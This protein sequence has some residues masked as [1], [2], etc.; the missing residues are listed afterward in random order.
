MV[1]TKRKKKESLRGDSFFLF[2]LFLQL[3]DEFWD[4]DGGAFLDV[5]DG[6]ADVGRFH[7]GRVGWVNDIDWDIRTDVC[8]KRCG[9]ID[10]QRCAYDDE[11]ISLLGYLDGFGEHRDRFAEEN[12]IRT[13]KRTIGMTG[14]EKLFPTVE[15]HC[16]QFVD[17]AAEFGDLAMQVS[18]VFGSGAFVEVINVLRD[19][20]DIVSLLQFRQSDMGSVRLAVEHLA[21]A[22]IIEVNDQFSVP[23][24]SLRGADILDAV[25][26]PE[27]IRVAE[28]GD[29][30]VF[31]DSC[32]CKNDNHSFIVFLVVDFCFCN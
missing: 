18:D 22:L 21:A 19:D 16:G 12:H 5:G 9:R 8:R 30:A 7:V 24:Q 15:R 14:I 4:S 20:M 23:G 1:I 17:R 26:C 11:D 27:T 3:D 29:A 6:I 28:S 25:V 13:E 32:S 2:V 31:A 10:I